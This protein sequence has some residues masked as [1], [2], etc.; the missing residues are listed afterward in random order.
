[1]N[2][3]LII[4]ILQYLIVILLAVPAYSK[5]TGAEETIFIFTELGVEPYGRVMIGLI[6]LLACAL[7]LVNSFAAIGA[8][9]ALG[10]M[11]GAIIAHVTVLG[12]EVLG[13]GG[14]LVFMLVAILILSIIVLY[15]RRKELPIIGRTL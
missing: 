7:L 15:N 2:K 8:L 10:L 5:L 9:L 13:D 4:K 6:E 14:G 11:C 1:M 3:N 12:F